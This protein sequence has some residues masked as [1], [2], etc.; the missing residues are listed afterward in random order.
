VGG[1]DGF[2]RLLGREQEFRRRAELASALLNA[3]PLK[4]GTYDEI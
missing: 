2:H 1:A 3:E 4:A